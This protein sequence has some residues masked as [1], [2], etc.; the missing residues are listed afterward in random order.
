MSARIISQKKKCTLGNATDPEDFS[1]E[2]VPD[3]EP[4]SVKKLSLSV[5]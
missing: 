3:L 2:M 5:I 4:M 1:R